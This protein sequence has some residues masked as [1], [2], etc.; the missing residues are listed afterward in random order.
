M[1]SGMMGKSFQESGLA[2]SS[3]GSGV[4]A[5]AA[6]DVGLEVGVISVGGRVAVPV[7]CTTNVGDGICSVE[8]GIISVP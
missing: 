2:G 3:V 4:K 7:G 8:V 5:V 1:V 6:G